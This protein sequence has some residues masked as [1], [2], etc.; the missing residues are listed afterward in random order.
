MAHLLIKFFVLLLLFGLS[1]HPVDAV[2]CRYCGRGEHFTPNDTTDEA[3]HPRIRKSKKQAFHDSLMKTFPYHFKFHK[4]NRVN[5][6]FPTSTFSGRRIDQWNVD[7]AATKDTFRVFFSDSFFIS[8]FAIPIKGNVTSDFGPRNLMGG[9]FH[10]GLDVSL[11]IGDS[12]RTVMDGVVRIAR[13]DVSGYG[14][15]VVVTH[16]NG[17]ESLYGHLSEHRVKEGQIV[18]AGQVI[19]L[20]GSTG[21]STGPHL[22]FEFRFMGEAFDAEQILNFE[23]GKLTA[24]TVVLDSSWFGHRKGN[25]C[26]D[27]HLVKKGESLKQIADKYRKKV[28]DIAKLNGLP[29]ETTSVPA[30]KRLRIG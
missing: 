12:V 1:Q 6:S 10:Y 20:G 24:Y 11:R 13:N 7:L 8:R 28:Y 23:R 27:Y 2:A 14:N 16:Y 29:P 3:D 22:H 21:R 4:G 15:F 26:K 30:G 9:T 19:G 18:K 25:F 5:Q 17:V